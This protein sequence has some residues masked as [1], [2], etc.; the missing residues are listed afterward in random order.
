MLKE[1]EELRGL[2]MYLPIY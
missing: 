2:E 1:N